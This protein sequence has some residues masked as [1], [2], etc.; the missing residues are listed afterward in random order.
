MAIVIIPPKNR[1]QNTEGQYPKSLILKKTRNVNNVI[2]VSA[3]QATGTK[4]NARGRYQLIYSQ[5]IRSRV[6]VIWSSQIV[7]TRSDIIPKQITNIYFARPPSSS[8]HLSLSSSRKKA[9]P[10]STPHSC[11]VLNHACKSD[12][13]FF[14][15]FL[16]LFKSEADLT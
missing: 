14:F 5:E 13:L 1:S 3:D 10:H 12:T 9:Y 16:F 15:S 4:K 6:C 7:C 8:S 11:I 2:V